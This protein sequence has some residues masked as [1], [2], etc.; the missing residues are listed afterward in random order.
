M[1]Y[2]RQWEELRLLRDIEHR[3]GLRWTAVDFGTNRGETALDMRDAESAPHA[4]VLAAVA[5]FPEWVRRM[6]GA[7]IPYVVISGYEHKYSFGDSWHNCLTVT[8]PWSPRESNRHTLQVRSLTEWDDQH[9]VAEFVG[10]RMRQRRHSAQSFYGRAVYEKK[11]YGKRAIR[12]ARAEA[13]EILAAQPNKTASAKTIFEA[14]SARHKGAWDRVDEE[15]MR[16]DLNAALQSPEFTRRITVT[17]SPA[18]QL[19]TLRW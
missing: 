8:A 5:H 6:D 19:I 2:D 12:Y 13:V 9:A 11:Q 10:P 7:E 1:I 3:R 16:Q 14:F 4:E 17:D 18:G 15:T